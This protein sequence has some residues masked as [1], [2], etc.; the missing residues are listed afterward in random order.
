MDARTACTKN[1]HFASRG[2]LGLRRHFESYRWT[3]RARDIQ[4]SCEHEDRVPSGLPAEAPSRCNLVRQS[5][6]ADAQHRRQRERMGTSSA[7]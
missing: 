6:K 5:E 4:G 2:P 3:V 1:L 7:S